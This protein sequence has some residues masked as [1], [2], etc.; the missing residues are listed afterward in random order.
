M[1]KGLKMGIYEGNYSVPDTVVRHWTQQAVDCYK[2]GCNCSKCNIPLIMETPC[3][4]KRSVIT[5]IRLYGVPDLRKFR[6]DNNSEI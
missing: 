5:L 3:Q 1:D 2:L 6:E 4:M